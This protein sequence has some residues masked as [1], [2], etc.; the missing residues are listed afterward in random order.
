[1]RGGSTIG[2][3]PEGLATVLGAGIARGV[4]TGG[5]IGKV[6]AALVEGGV[7]ATRA[8]GVAWDGAEKQS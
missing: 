5:A 6:T 8:S 7:A 3:M 1:M 2:T 4:S